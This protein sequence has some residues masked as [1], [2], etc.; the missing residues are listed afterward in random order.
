MYP[1]SNLILQAINGSKEN[2]LKI[3]KNLN[4][5]NLSKGLRRLDQLIYTGQCPGSM[6]DRLPI[7]LGLNPEVIERAFKDTLIQQKEEEEESRIRREE[8]DRF[9]F[10]PHIWICHEFEKPPLGSICIVGLIG[11]EHWKIIQLPDDIE[12]KPWSKQFKLV[13]EKIRENQQS[14]DVGRGIF[15]KVFG[16]LYRKA[17]VKGFIFSPDGDLLE[18]YSSKIPHLD[19]QVRLGKGNVLGRIL[20]P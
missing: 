3:V 8:Q 7:A 13:R 2:K 10:R 12:R 1:I 5:T 18:I 6:R 17:Y 20:E 19:I 11:I 4:F 14:E 15:G 16:Y 9:S